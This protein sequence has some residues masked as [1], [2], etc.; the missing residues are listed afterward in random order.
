MF[1]FLLLSFTL[2]LMA[3]LASLA[4]A[5][6]TLTPAP[7]KVQAFPF[8]QSIAVEPA[9]SW[10]TTQ[11]GLNTAMKQPH[12]KAQAKAPKP[13]TPLKAKPSKPPKK[14]GRIYE[15]FHRKEK[16][17]TVTVTAN[18]LATTVKPTAA[19]AL[20]SSIAVT[21]PNYWS[22]G[23]APRPDA[24]TQQLM[25]FITQTNPRISPYVAQL[26]ATC[27]IGAGQTYEVDPL[28]IASLIATESSFRPD[29]VSVTGAKGMGQ[30]KDDTATWLGVSDSFNVEQNIYGTAKYLGYLGKKFPNNPAEAVASYYVGQGTVQRQGLSDD[31][32][33]YVQKVQTHLLQLLS[34]GNV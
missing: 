26:L 7:V 13:P 9:A 12:A 17:T 29:A 11:Q 32:I 14:H 31:A 16:P 25:Q 19:M 15:F 20:S 24:L 1:R 6:G 30:L 21:L 28:L 10:Q 22:E 34:L 3:S 33:R 27:M 18:S 5:D 2:L 8:A 23:S 4:H